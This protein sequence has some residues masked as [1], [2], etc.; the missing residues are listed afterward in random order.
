MV[1]DCRGQS[2]GRAGGKVVGGRW[3]EELNLQEAVPAPSAGVPGKKGIEKETYFLF[4]LWAG[5]S[6]ELLVGR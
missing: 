5:G 4:Q 2:P 3:E 1:G 6:R